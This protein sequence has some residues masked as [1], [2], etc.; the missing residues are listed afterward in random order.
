MF[1]ETYRWASR[2]RNEHTALTTCRAAFSAAYVNNSLRSPLAP[3]LT[4]QGC[5]SERLGRQPNVTQPGLP[6]RHPGAGTA[7]GRHADHTR[8]RVTRSHAP[9]HADHT[10][11]AITRAHHA[12]HTRR[13]HTHTHVT[14][15]HAHTHHAITRAH[16]SRNHT[17]PIM[18][19]THVT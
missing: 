1:H 14:R 13:D 2:K 12:D 4:D 3:P 10:R 16:T 7:H 6:R 19:I 8:T 5:G 9:H 15:S 17:H 11:H 18:L